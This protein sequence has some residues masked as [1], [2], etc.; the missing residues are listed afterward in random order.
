MWWIGSFVMFSTAVFV[1]AMIVHTGVTNIKTIG[2]PLVVPFVGT[3]T[4]AVV[5]A[6]IVSYSDGVNAR[7]AIPVIIV[8]YILCGVGTW[9]GL[10]AFAL[11]W[12][13]FVNYGPTPAALSPGLFLL[14]GPPGQVAAAVILLGYASSLYFGAYDTGTFFT[15]TSGATLYTVGV[16]FGL[17]VLGLAMLFIFFALYTV[18]DVAFRRQHSYS[19]IWWSTIFPMA[20]VNT[21]FIGLA[22]SLDS[23]AFRALAEALYVILFIDYVINMGFTLTHIAQ[24]KLLS[25]R[26]KEDEKEK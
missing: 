22:T 12:A 26:R 13:R 10:L 1:F 18:I 11:I 8:S 15:V 5:G 17:L 14:V 19:L 25:G 24:G 16:F 23:P 3:T 6:L 7:L 9:A 20:T 4:D 2:P 21:A